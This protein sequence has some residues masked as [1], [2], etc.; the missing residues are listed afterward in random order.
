MNTFFRRII[1]PPYSLSPGVSDQDLLVSLA[2]DHYVGQLRSRPISFFVSAVLY[3]PTYNVYLR[4]LL[5]HVR[6]AFSSSSAY[7]PRVVNRNLLQRFGFADVPV[8]YPDQPPPPPTGDEACTDTEGEHVDVDL[9]QD[10]AS[11][12][13]GLDA[14][15]RRQETHVASPPAYRVTQ[16]QEPPRGFVFK[17]GHDTA[18]VSASSNLHGAHFRSPSEHRAVHG[19]DHH[20][21]AFALLGSLP[22]QP[23][24]TADYGRGHPIPHPT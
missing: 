18:D 12:L 1:S 13:R 2:S 8:A 10:A 16:R 4:S 19:A 24:S 22:C 7:E 23:N 15:E 9:A 6:K 17:R 5:R 14:Q 11:T 20:C 21:Q 3:D